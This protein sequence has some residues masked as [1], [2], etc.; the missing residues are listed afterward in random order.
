MINIITTGYANDNIVLEQFQYFIKNKMQD[1]QFFFIINSYSLY[2]T[3]LFSNLTTKNKIILFCLLLYFIDLIQS[4]DIK[5]FN[6]SSIIIQMQLTKLFDWIIKNL[7]N[8]NFWLF[9]SHFGIKPSNQQL[10]AILSSQ[11]D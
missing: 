3:L 5:V 10:F 1:I 2:M 7:A 8:Q 4:L 11:L 6:L 9:S